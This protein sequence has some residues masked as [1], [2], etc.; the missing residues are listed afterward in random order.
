MGCISDLVIANA[1][2]GMA[3]GPCRRMRPRGVY[4]SL[5]KKNYVLFMA[6]QKNLSVCPKNMLTSREQIAKILHKAYTGFY[7]PLTTTRT[8][9]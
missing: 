7:F 6:C 4:S 2:V 9:S 8:D 3:A 5:G 1:A